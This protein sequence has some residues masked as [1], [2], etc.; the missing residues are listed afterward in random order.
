MISRLFSITP[1]LA[2]TRDTL[3]FSAPQG[4]SQLR[5]KNTLEKRLR[6]DITRELNDVKVLEEQLLKHLDLITEKKRQ[7][8]IKKRQ[9]VQVRSGTLLWCLFASKEETI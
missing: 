5:G 6:E 3:S 7:L 2:L 4:Y 9:P 1:D 8:E